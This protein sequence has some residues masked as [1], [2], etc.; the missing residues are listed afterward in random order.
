QFYLTAADWVPEL[1]RVFHLRS[2][3]EGGQTSWPIILHVRHK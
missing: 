1:T 3:E 2:K